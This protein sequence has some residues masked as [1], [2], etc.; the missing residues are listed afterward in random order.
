MKTLFEDE[1]IN[2][3]AVMTLFRQLDALYA[4][5][6]V[7]EMLAELKCL[8]VAKQS[9]LLAREL[10]MRERSSFAG[11]FMDAIVPY[12]NRFWFKT[13]HMTMP[14]M[15]IPY[16]H[17]KFDAKDEF[18]TECLQLIPAFH[19]SFGQ[20][21]LGKGMELTKL[22]LAHE[23]SRTVKSIQFY[24]KLQDHP[25]IYNKF[26]GFNIPHAP[27]D[28]TMDEL[29]GSPDLAPLV[30]HIKNIWCKGDQTLF[31]YVMC[32][33]AQVYQR[34][35]DQT[36][37]ALVVKGARGS[38][39]GVVMEFLAAIIGENHYWHVTNLN[40]MCGTFVAPK[41]LICCLGFADE[42]YYGG[43][44]SQSQ[45]LKQMI[46]ERRITV[47][48]KH[49]AQYT[50]DSY[51]NI[52]I[53]S[54]DD[55]IIQAGKGER[56][57]QALETDN[58][59]AG[60]ETP[61]TKAYYAKIR[62]CCPRKFAALLSLMDLTN[63]SPRAI[64]ETAA[65]RDQQILSA[66]PIDRYWYDCLTN[67]EIE[68]GKTWP[69]TIAISDF[70]ACFRAY[71]SQSGVKYAADSQVAF[72]AQISKLIDRKD[73]ARIRIKSKSAIAIPSVADCM[74]HFNA[75]MGS[76]FFDSDE[77]QDIVYSTNMEDTY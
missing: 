68:Y 48:I 13:T 56:R 33:F 72:M 4:F 43:D 75:A 71:V 47:N 41:R 24:P 1:E 32:W 10:K 16:V 29:Y 25:E 60:A 54:N 40:D 19:I 14:V 36:G 62:A 35:W 26:R 45:G 65:H 51:T 53:A 57:F 34:P 73:K 52:V 63:F 49:V 20:W 23:H 37:V 27:T 30:E 12:L 77:M 2:L 44:P 6:P 39:K 18:H 67:R 3:P 42:C 69:L 64:H 74:K 15:I 9:M 11:Y 58:R 38:G 55:R 61:E 17:P 66:D 50:I 46:T 28:Y 70:Y 59:Y 22:W 21:K 31:T 5:R 8:S 7:E 76:S